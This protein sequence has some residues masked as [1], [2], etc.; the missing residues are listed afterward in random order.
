MIIIK[1]D[2]ICIDNHVK[3]PLFCHIAIKFNFTDRYSQNPQTSSF[4]KICVVEPSCFI[5]TDRQTDRQAGRS[6]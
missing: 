5:Q 1:P 4:M 2:I 3:Y 6:T